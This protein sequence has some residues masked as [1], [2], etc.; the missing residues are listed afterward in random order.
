MRLVDRGRGPQ[1]EFVRLPTTL[2]DLYAEA[3]TDRPFYLYEAETLTFAEAYQHA[4]RLAVVL[5]DEFGV[6]RGDRVALA[7]HNLPEWPVAFMAT[8][9]LGATAVAVNSMWQRDDMEAALHDADACVLFVDQQRLDRLTGCSLPDRLRVVVV[10]PTGDIG[11]ATAYDRLMARVDDM[12]MPLARVEPDDP[13]CMFFTSGS[14]GR[15]KGVPL[16]HRNVLTTLFAWQL[17]ARAASLDDGAGADTSTRSVTLL[18]TPLFHVLGAISILLDAFVSQ[19]TVVAMPKWDAEQAAALIERHRVTCFNA[20]AAITTDLERIARTTPHDLSS[21][22]TVGGGGS[23]R[24]PEQVARLTAR[25]GKSVAATGWGMTETAALGT[26]ISGLDYAARP[27]SVGRVEMMIDLRL[28]DES[29]Q[30]VPPG[31]RGEVQVR[32]A[33]VFRGYWR[34]PD[35]DAEAFTAD[36]WFRTGDIALI[37]D[38]GFVFIVD[39]SKDLI[40]RGGEN[41]GCGHVEAALLTHPSV[42]EAAVYAVPDERLGEEI[43]ATVHVSARISTDPLPRTASGK[44]LKRQVRDE[45][46]AEQL[47]DRASD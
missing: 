15:S 31:E 36:G 21:L 40:I 37:D 2:R 19:T 41:I 8:T 4:A 35:A 45:A 20:P 18:S 10:R 24:A 47:P 25:F 11:D 3:A 39:R 22:T 6:R 28:V 46:L 33:S 17:A 16:T 34:R 38:D 29:D 9:A 14:T 12:A 7:M 1:R 42:E 43:G 13:A 5:A 44:V 32:G 26:G 23:S 30:P 27:G